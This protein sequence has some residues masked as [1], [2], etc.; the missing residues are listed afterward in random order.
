[1]PEANAN[2]PAPDSKSA[3]VVSKA[4]RVGFPLRV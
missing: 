1:M 4:F 3:S 2:P